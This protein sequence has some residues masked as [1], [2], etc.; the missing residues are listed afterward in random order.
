MFQNRY[1]IIE[2]IDLISMVNLINTLQQC[3]PKKR[4]KSFHTYRLG[5]LIYTLLFAAKCESALELGVGFGATILMSGLALKEHTRDN[6]RLFGLDIK[7]HRLK[8]AQELLSEYGIVGELTLADASV[9][10]WAQEVDAIFIDCGH[11]VN[12]Y[13]LDKYGLFAKKLIII[14]DVDGQLV[15]P[16]GFSH[17]YIKEANCMVASKVICI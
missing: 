8:H 15:F 12:Q 4:I 6:Y 11:R 1:Y 16:A 13:M 14:H 2:D 17:I 3:F 9:Y 5:F 7:E 10:P